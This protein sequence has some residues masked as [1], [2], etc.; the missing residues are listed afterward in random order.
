MA[1]SASPSQSSKDSASSN[2]EDQLPMKDTL[3]PT[4]EKRRKKTDSKAEKALQPFPAVVL[5][6][7][8]SERFYVDK[9]AER[10]YRRV[11]TLHRPACPV[12][13]SSS[14]LGAFTRSSK[15]KKKE[16]KRYFSTKFQKRFKES[17]SKSGSTAPLITENEFLET[18]KLLNQSTMCNV[19]NISA[20]VDLVQFQDQTPMKNIPKTQL[21]E[22]KF[23]ILNKALVHNPLSDELYTVYLNI[24]NEVLPSFEVSKIVEKL[25]Q[26]DPTNYI[27]WR[28]LIMA[29]QGSMARCSVPDVMK[30]YERAMQT[31]YR[32]R[33]CDETMLSECNCCT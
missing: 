30:L 2:E 33:R 7:D 15:K 8:G 22:R 26:K 25:L 31:N 20:W 16:F 17:R 23:D 5:N 14:R 29:T 9:K 18:N 21:A 27:L 32:K 10:E 13:H 4:K 19:Q 24:A 12:Y 11:D 3:K 28:G 6:F 1:A